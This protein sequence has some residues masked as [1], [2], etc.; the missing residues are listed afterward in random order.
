MW[1]TL[2]QVSNF[3]FTIF[4]WP[5]SGLSAGWQIFVLAVP[6]TIL[7][8]L[9]FKYSSNQ[10]GIKLNKDKIK[11]YLLEMR[12]FKDDLG[13][14]LG[15]EKKILR[16]TAA[17]LGYALLPMAVMII[18]FILI[19]VQ[20]ESRFAF[21][22]LDL[23][24]QVIL[25]VTMDSQKPVHDID[26][27]LELPSGLSK[28]TPAMRVDD[29]QEIL[30]RIRGD[31]AGIYHAVLKIDN[32]SVEK[33]LVV[34]QGALPLSPTVYRANDIR[35]VGYPI[36]PTLDENLSVSEV[37]VAYPRARAEFAGLSSASWLLVLY[38]IVLGFLMRG[39]FGVTF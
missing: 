27:S 11:A 12:L 14:T 19:L 34:D 39:F 10:E 15:A 4:L 24:E 23:G 31:K 33:K 29:T 32:Q 35:S 6:A 22:S 18:P 1:A 38:T 25:S 8:L 7:S 3:V 13:V 21:K 9:V 26:S 5:F 17:Y 20:V 2:N 36:E 16:H 37:T 30:W 28:T